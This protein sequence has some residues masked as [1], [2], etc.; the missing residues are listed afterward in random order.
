MT[1]GYLALLAEK[2]LFGG[3]GEK[4]GYLSKG[5]IKYRT[6]DGINVNDLW[7]EFEDTLTL[8]NEHLGALIQLLTFPV[9]S[10]VELVPRV[11]EVQFEAATEYG[12]PKSARVEVD[13]YELAYD[14]KDYD[15][16]L[17]YTWMYL[18]DADA[19]QVRAIHGRA[20]EAD[21]ALI[22]RKVMEAVFDNR[23]RLANINGLPYNVYPLYNADGVVPPPYK[24]VEFDGSHSHYLVSAGGVSYIDPTDH[25]DA[26]EHLAHHGYGLDTGTQIVA[27]GHKAEINVVKT[28]KKGTSYNSQVALY[29]FIPSPAQPPFFLPNAQGLL[30][31]L[32]PDFW[33]GLRVQ[34]SYGDVLYIE[35]PTFPAGYVLYMATGGAGALENLVGL[36]EHQD[37]AWQGLRLLP[38]NQSRY[39]LVDSFY[40]RSF[41]T[42]IRQ[43]G[44]AVVLQ[45]KASGTYDIPTK[46]KK[47]LGFK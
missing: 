13:Y 3:A 5:D 40:Q 28:W 33:R 6:N 47:G 32:P 36:R 35:E 20:L 21:R 37:P 24:G 22:F 17:R 14:F 44:G 38:G 34:G 10:L 7:L 11:G 45:I 29:D 25:E 23:T 8:Y 31:S 2:P 1:V 15:L 42:G 43:R 4:G 41:G 16:A 39:P 19:R 18:R 46:F 26:V 12:V 9:R 27:L 30:G